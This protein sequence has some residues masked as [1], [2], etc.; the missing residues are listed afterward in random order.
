M[1]SIMYLNGKVYHYISFHL[2]R[3]HHGL[4]ILVPQPG[5]EPGPCQGSSS[6]YTFQKRFQDFSGGSSGKESPCQCRRQ[7][8]SL[9]CKDTHV[10]WSKGACA[11]HLL[12]SHLEPGSCNTEPMRSR[13]CAPQQGKPAHHRW[14]GAPCSL[15]AAGDPGPAQPQINKF[16]KN[17]N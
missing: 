12:C 9:V 3:L 6:M 1:L 17:L 4:R 5:I 2:F 7:V 13:T 16:C 8:Q 10:P 14:R 15:T 11:P